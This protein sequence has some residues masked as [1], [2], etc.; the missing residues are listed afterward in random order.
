MVT[1]ENGTIK[2]RG[3]DVKEWHQRN[4]QHADIREK[5]ERHADVRE[6]EKGMLTKER[7]EDVGEKREAR[8]RWRKERPVLPPERPS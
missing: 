5:R 1:S 4:E 3:E 7:H 2:K 8:G 6:R